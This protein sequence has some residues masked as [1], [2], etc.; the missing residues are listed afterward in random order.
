[1]RLYGDIVSG[2]ECG[3]VYYICA[4]VAEVSYP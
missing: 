2:K 1:M 3:L 4:V